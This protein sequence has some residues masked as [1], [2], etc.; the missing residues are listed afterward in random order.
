MRV[1]RLSVV[2]K[3]CLLPANALFS[4]DIIAYAIFICNILFSESLN[5]DNLYFQLIFVNIKVFYLLHHSLINIKLLGSDFVYI[6]IF[7]IRNIITQVT[8]LKI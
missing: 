8:I 5:D 7:N 1:S 2:P 4:I 3:G 6:P